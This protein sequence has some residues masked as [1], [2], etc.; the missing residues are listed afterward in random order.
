MG[1]L[2]SGQTIQLHKLL[3]NDFMV[4]VG[5]LLQ[6]RELFLDMIKLLI[7][8]VYDVQKLLVLLLEVFLS[9]QDRLSQE[10]ARHFQFFIL[11]LLNGVCPAVVNE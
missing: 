5:F 9:D 11:I 4:I 1:R 10:L 8:L 2:S 7:K 6:R 3:V